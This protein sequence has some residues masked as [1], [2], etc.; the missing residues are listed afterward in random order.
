MNPMEAVL[1]TKKGGRKPK[2]ESS[3][4]KEYVA[5]KCRTE[6]KNWLIRFAASQEMEQSNLI[7]KALAAFAAARGFEAPP[8]R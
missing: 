8:E 7:E 3:K 6:F 4:M 2:P 1:M 5:I